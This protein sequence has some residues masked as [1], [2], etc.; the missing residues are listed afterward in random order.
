MRD[1]L[2]DSS[3]L[4]DSLDALSP[5]GHSSQVSSRNSKSSFLILYNTCENTETKNSNKEQ[6]GPV[7]SFFTFPNGKLLKRKE[8]SRPKR[9]INEILMSSET[10]KGKTQKNSIENTQIN[11]TFTSFSPKMSPRGKEWTTFKINRPTFQ[12]FRTSSREK[13]YS[14]G[15]SECQSPKNK[16]RT[17]GWKAMNDEKDQKNLKG[18]EE[19]LPNEEMEKSMGFGL[20]YS[21]IHQK[22]LSS[23]GIFEPVI[24]EILDS[25][26]SKCQIKMKTIGAISKFPLDKMIELAIE[27]F[28]LFFS[29]ELLQR[30]LSGGS[31]KDYFF[32]EFLQE[33]SKFIGY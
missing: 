24:I 27:K 18:T 15:K 21:E 13:N 33:L 30:M 19:S 29:E 22:V 4:L 14:K 3:F 12:K 2:D 16:E 31:K 6:K 20:S 8:I 9:T 1:N 5:R 28:H 26:F 23:F 7:Q 32:R 25:S 10:P 17:K 11:S